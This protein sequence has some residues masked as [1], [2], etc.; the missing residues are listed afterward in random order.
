MVYNIYTM[1]KHQRGTVSELLSASYFVENGYVVSK[2]LT[3]FNEYDLVVDNGTL[4]RVQV[5]TAYWDTNKKR[6]LVSCVTSHIRG[7]NNRYNKKYTQESFD[8]LCA[9]EQ[10]TNSIYLIPINRIAK[11]RSITLYPKGKPDTIND[12]YKDFED[13]RVQ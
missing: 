1:N 2:P 6:Y 9:V 13:C 12:R 10:K 4:H 11:R 3:D 5:K 7:N 8:Y